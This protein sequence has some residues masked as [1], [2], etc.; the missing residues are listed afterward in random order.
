MYADSHVAIIAAVAQNGV[1]GS[2]GTIPW[3]SSEY[4]GEMDHFR[5]QT[6]TKGSNTVV[7]GR[8]T[9]ESID[10]RY[11]PLEGRTNIVITSNQSFRSDGAIRADSLEQALERSQGGVWLIGG[12]RVYQEG[13]DKGYVDSILLSM[14]PRSYEGDTYFPPIP[15]SFVSVE[16]QDMGRFMIVTY[17]RD[18]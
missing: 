5:K 6:S 4:P 3:E 15:R 16:E 9:W 17:V 13:L 11:R 7:M 1:I 14:L 12:E 8:K 18:A 2:A 10:E